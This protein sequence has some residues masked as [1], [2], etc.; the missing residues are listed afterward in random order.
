[1]ELKNNLTKKRTWK[2]VWDILKW[3]KRITAGTNSSVAIITFN[4]MTLNCFY[5]IKFHKTS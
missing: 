3:N 2:K 5:A 1:M 4:T